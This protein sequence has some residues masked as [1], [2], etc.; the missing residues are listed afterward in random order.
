VGWGLFGSSGE[1]ERERAGGGGGVMGGGETGDSMV[2]EYVYSFTIYPLEKCVITEDKEI[3]NED[4]YYWRYLVDVYILH[5][6]II[7]TTPPEE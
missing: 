2:Y 7:M 5:D 4:I 3:N 6:G 1:G